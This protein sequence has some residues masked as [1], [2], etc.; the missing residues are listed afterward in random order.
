[1]NRLNALT[2]ITSLND[3][4]RVKQLDQQPDQRHLLKLPFIHDAN[5]QLSGSML[6]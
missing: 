3:S 5:D 4:A 6:A 2:A 1:M